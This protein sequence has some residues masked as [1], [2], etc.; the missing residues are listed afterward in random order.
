M[1][2]V[3]QNDTGVVLVVTCYDQNGNPIDLTTATSVTLQ[4]YINPIIPALTKTMDVNS[5]VD[6]IVQYTFSTYTDDWGNTHYDLGYPGTLYFRVSIAFPSS[7]VVTS[8]ASG[9]ITV[10]PSFIEPSGYNCS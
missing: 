10:N 2:N 8:W 1:A 4:F 7:V 5:A 6:G 3:V 9:E